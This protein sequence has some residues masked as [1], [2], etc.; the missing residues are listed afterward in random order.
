MTADGVP[1]VPD[2]NPE[3]M[4][5]VVGG[6]SFPEKFEKS[7]VGLNLGDQ[8]TITL[9]PE[10]AFGQQDVNLIKRVAKDAL[11]PNLRSAQEGQI[12]RASNP[13]GTQVVIRIVQVMDDSIVIDQN[14]P[15][16]GR[17]LV[18]NVTVKSIS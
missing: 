17:T 8:K 12:L 3:T 18:Y 4:L 9:S 13:D 16:A 5:L 15:L 14:H 2:D 11:P 6:G 1:V 7:L 10:E